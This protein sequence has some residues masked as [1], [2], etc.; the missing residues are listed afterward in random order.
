MNR[1]YSL[2]ILAA[3]TL[4]FL[5]ISMYSTSDV[6]ASGDKSTKDSFDEYCPCREY[7]DREHD[8]ER[9][10]NEGYDNGEKHSGYYDQYESGYFEDRYGIPYYK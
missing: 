4:A 2:I 7:D 10:D 9:D 3:S 5:S 8:D 6:Y 1:T